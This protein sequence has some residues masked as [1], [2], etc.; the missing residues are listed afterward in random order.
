MHIT[1]IPLEMGLLL[2]VVKLKEIKILRVILLFIQLCQHVL[3]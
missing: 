3:I 1:G 2:L